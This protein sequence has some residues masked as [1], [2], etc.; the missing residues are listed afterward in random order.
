MGF[1][2]ETPHIKKTN[3]FVTCAPG[4]PIRT[5]MDNATT[6]QYAALLHQLTGKTKTTVRDL[7]P[8]N[9]LTFLRIRTQKHEIMVAPG[10]EGVLSI[11]CSR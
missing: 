11:L 10:E 5:T 8:N 9:E 7:D 6:V 1:F 2:D 4:I 3:C